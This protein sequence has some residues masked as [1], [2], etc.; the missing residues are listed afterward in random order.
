MLQ[1]V[2]ALYSINSKVIV[3]ICGDTQTHPPPPYSETLGVPCS[4]FSVL[5][6]CQ[7]TCAPEER[8]WEVP[9]RERVCRQT[10]QL[11]II[12]G[13]PLS[14]GCCAH[15]LD[16]QSLKRICSQTVIRDWRK[17]DAC[18]Y[19]RYMGIFVVSCTSDFV[20]CF[21]LKLGSTVKW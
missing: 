21:I 14:V 12:W 19:I 4:L 11:E 10:L 8:L 2:H 9:A 7:Q 18:K 3:L 13:R 17:I 15:A 1:F 20:I 5:A 6:V 16:K